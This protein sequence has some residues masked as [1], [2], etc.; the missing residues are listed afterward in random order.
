[1]SGVSHSLADGIQCIGMNGV[2]FQGDQVSKN[3][4]SRW[5]CD[6]HV[7]GMA[8]SCSGGYGGALQLMTSTSQCTIHVHHIPEL[9]WGLNQS[10]QDKRGDRCWVSLDLQ[11]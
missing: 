3:V 8:T 10:N 1:M 7:V 9:D 11:H 5:M 6:L 4:L 2:L